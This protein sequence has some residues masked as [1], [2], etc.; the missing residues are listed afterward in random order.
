MSPFHIASYVA[1]GAGFW[2]IVS[3]W[4]RLHDAAQAGRLASDGP[5]ARVRHPQYAGFIAIMVGFLLQWPTLP[6]LAMFPVLLVMYRRLAI[7]EEREVAAEFPGEWDAYAAQTPRF[8]PRL[9]HARPVVHTD[10]I[11][12]AATE[13]MQPQRP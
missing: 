8:I 5:Y 11:R 10:P 2:L 7:R 6:T 4:S 12:A 1:I 9:R 3:A 13:G